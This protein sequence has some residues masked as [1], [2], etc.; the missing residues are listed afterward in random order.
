MA[1]S[2]YSAYLLVTSLNSRIFPIHRLV[3]QNKRQEYHWSRRHSILTL[4]VVSH[5]L[6][7]RKIIFRVLHI[8]RDEHSIEIRGYM[9]IIHKIIY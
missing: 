6:K 8:I 1:P 4:N 5:V 2:Q 7:Q 9:N 3:N